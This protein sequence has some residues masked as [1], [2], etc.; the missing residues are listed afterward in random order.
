MERLTEAD[1]YEAALRARAA[2]GR[3]A[4]LALGALLVAILAGASLA[5]DG[6]Y[7]LAWLDFWGRGR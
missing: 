7:H 3:R 6:L 2:R 1:A 5:V 4:A